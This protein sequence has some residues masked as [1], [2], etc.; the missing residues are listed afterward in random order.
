VLWRENL[1]VSPTLIFWVRV[2][3]LAEFL[4]LASLVTV[5]L[6]SLRA[7]IPSPS[8]LTALLCTIVV[9]TVQVVGASMRWSEQRPYP[10]DLR[11]ARATPAPPIVMVGYSAR[12]AIVTTLTGLVFSGLARVPEPAISVFFAILFLTWSSI[13]LVRSSHRWAVP[14]IRAR[15]VTVVAG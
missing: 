13:R 4:A 7:G 3:V 12:L 15:V 14:E 10:V 8:E 9:V 6:G 5:L 11:S 1:P 2:L